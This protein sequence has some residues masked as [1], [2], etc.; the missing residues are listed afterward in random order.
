MFWVFFF[1]L[2]AFHNAREN[3]AAEG[4]KTSGNFT[5]MLCFLQALSSAKHKKIPANWEWDSSFAFFCLDFFSLSPWLT[6]LVLH[7]PN[8]HLPSTNCFQIPWRSCKEQ[9]VRSAHQLLTHRCTQGPGGGGNP[10]CSC[11]T[12]LSLNFTQSKFY[13]KLW[14]LKQAE[15]F[16]ERVL[17]STLAGDHSSQRGQRESWE[18][19]LIQSRQ[20]CEILW[21]TGLQIRFPL[22]WEPVHF[23]CI[24]C[25]GPEICGSP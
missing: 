4:Q 21:H 8:C 6:D 16:V 17:C 1:S 23:L 25:C 7:F 12:F 10:S 19:V 20:G 3:A 15:T 14:F 18:P 22:P 13:G 9:P 24:W 11:P 5:A 2:N